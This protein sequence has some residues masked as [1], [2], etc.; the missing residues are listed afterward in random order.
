MQEPMYI[1]IHNQIKRD[2]ENKKY[3]VGERIP[4]ERQL[5]LKFNVSRMTLRQAIKT[6]ED[7]GILERRLGSGTYVSSQKVQEK[8]SGIMSFTDITRA[9]GQVPSSKLLSYRVTKPSL[10]EKE[11]LKIKDT[12]NV[13]RMERVRFADNVPAESYLRQALLPHSAASP[14]LLP[15]KHAPCAEGFLHERKCCT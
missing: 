3:K 11:K 9:N 6:F 7:E 15:R 4:A 14:H 13:L 2:I 10:S 8:M 12:D 5:A 1:K